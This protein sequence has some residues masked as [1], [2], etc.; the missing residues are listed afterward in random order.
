MG[1]LKLK[2]IINRLLQMCI[3]DILNL[4]SL[5]IATLAENTSLSTVHR[6]TDGMN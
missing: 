2:D 4:V 1:Y 5:K 6:E 3:F